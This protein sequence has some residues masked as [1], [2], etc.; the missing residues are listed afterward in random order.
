MPSQ[1]ISQ[2]VGFAATSS[3]RLPFEA[4]CR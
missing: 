2:K 4:T 3:Y 1:A